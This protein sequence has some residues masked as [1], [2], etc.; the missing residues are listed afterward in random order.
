MRK[1]IIALT[2]LILFLVG[3]SVG[4]WFLAIP[5]DLLKDVMTKSWGKGNLYFEPEGFEKGALYSFRAGR[6]LLKNRKSAEKG[7]FLLAVDQVEGRLIPASMIKL[8][9]EVEFSGRIKE[10]LVTGTV[11]FA[12]KKAIRVHGKDVP[13]K[14]IPYLESLGIR[15]DGKLSWDL[16]LV[17]GAGEAKFSLTDARL[18]G[19]QLKGFF[20][21]LDMFEN[22][23]G[24]FVISQDTIDVQSLALEGRGVYARA[25]G[26]VTGKSL[27]LN[28]E[29]MRDSSLQLDPS[30]VKLL[31]PYQ[32]SPGYYVIPVKQNLP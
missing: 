2:F 26:K 19:A 20:L 24:S 14:G 27:D 10:G 16:S 31:E 21:P 25:K 18:K 3:L 9:P 6:I 32:V 13:I 23:R 1:V 30:V 15:G 5:E 29:L 17:D 28:M 4:L 8:N 11:T 12:G 7:D 22:A